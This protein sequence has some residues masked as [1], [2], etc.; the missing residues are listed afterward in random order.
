MSSHAARSQESPAR[1]FSQLC[2]PLWECLHDQAALSV[3]EY[4]IQFMAARDALHLLQFWFSVASFK[5]AS[6]SSSTAAAP[7]NHS[8]TLAATS[9][10]SGSHVC[11]AET[12]AIGTVQS[13]P[14]K[15][16]HNS[17]LMKSA[18]S[19]PTSLPTTPDNCTEITPTSASCHSLGGSASVPIQLYKEEAECDSLIKALAVRQMAAGDDV[20]GGGGASTM[21]GVGGGREGDVTVGREGQGS[22]GGVRNGRPEEITRQTSLS[23]QLSLLSTIPM[24]IST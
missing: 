8:H 17:L 14:M 9:V 15:A 19:I 7:L 12:R 13:Q 16:D 10:V 3:L 18:N 11:A 5:S 6:H 21:N 4:L 20:H 22:V 24:G 23:K 1:R 2:K